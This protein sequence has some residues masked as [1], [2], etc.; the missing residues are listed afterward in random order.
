MSD[1]S[2]NEMALDNT[3]YFEVFATDSEEEGSTSQS[4]HCI[5]IP[6]S[7]NPIDFDTEDVPLSFLRKM[8]KKETTCAYMNIKNVVWR[9]RCLEK[10]SDDGSC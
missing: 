1:F 7:S 8:Q 2:D 4:K 5:V 9:S 10:S 3:N 6:K